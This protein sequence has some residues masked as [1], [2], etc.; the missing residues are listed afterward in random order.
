VPKSE[1][2]PIKKETLKNDI[3]TKISK[4]LEIT[5]NGSKLS[6]YSRIIVN[7]EAISK[8]FIY[9]FPE[10]TIIRTI[11]KL[12]SVLPYLI[13]K[14][15]KV[16]NLTHKRVYVYYMAI[17][18][19]YLSYSEEKLSPRY[20]DILKKQRLIGESKVC[21]FL[22][23]K[24]KQVELQEKNLLEKPKPLQFSDLIKKRILTMLKLYSKAKDI[25]Y[26]KLKLIEEKA[27]QLLAKGIKPHINLDEAAL[28]MILVIMIHYNVERRTRSEF[29]E[30]LSQRYDLDKERIRRKTQEFRR[31]I[32][33]HDLI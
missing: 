2:Q 4:V 10:E 18:D 26:E 12:I 23:M 17:L 1:E 11:D 32:K 22:E 27:F 3:I 25:K 30:L 8:V 5:Q 15:G 29:R 14:Y 33:E 16:R 9:Y 19:T 7:I 31:R 21:S 24:R 28:V 20:F 6:Q 13:E